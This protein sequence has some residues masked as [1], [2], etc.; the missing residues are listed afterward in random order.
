[1]DADFKGELYGAYIY[2]EVEFP[3]Q[4]PPALKKSTKFSDK[5]TFECKQPNLAKLIKWNRLK[6]SAKDEF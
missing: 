2:I 6:K 1:M 4:N 5:T 3:Y